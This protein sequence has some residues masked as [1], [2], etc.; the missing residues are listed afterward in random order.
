MDNVCED[1]LQIICKNNKPYGIRDRSGFLFFFPDISKYPGQEERYSQEI[2][3]QHKLAD[4]LLN[5]LQNII[6]NTNQLE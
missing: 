1:K 2:E 3:Q 6:N 4:Y 5:A